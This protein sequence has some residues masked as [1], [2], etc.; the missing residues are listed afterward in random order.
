MRTSLGIVVAIA[1]AACAP[2]VDGP[3]E[4]QRA[5][6]RDDGDRLALQLAQLPGAVSA[7]VTLHRAARD[8]LGVSPPSPASAAALI[9][10]D[11]QANRAAV[12]QAATTLVRAAAPEITA[13]AIVVEVGVVRPTLAKVGPFT[14]EASSKGTLKAVLAIA[15]AMIAGLA[16]WIALSS[17]RAT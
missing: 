4:R 1:L 10:V 13:P 11:D 16:G 3:V 17:R 7:Q 15:L 6:D 14:V 9:I 5:V 2:T 12:T 8:P